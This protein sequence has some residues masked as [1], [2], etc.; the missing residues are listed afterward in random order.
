MRTYRGATVL[1]AR[2][3]ADPRRDQSVSVAPY[4]AHRTL[5]HPSANENSGP[6]AD[7]DPG[8]H[9]ALGR[10]AQLYWRRTRRKVASAAT[11]T[12]GSERIPGS[13]WHVGGARMRA[14]PREVWAGASGWARGAPIAYLSYTSVLSREASIRRGPVPVTVPVT[15]TLCPGERLP[16][17]RLVTAGAAT[18]WATRAETAR[19]TR[20]HSVSF[21]RTPIRRPPR[22]PHLPRPACSQLYGSMSGSLRRPA[23]QAR[24]TAGPWA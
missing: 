11:I 9:T 12:H 2:A 7:A 24:A 8:A 15:A 3:R 17:A 19:A 4:P 22:P 16:L 5:R 23:W 18:P 13:S 6:D 21:P 14:G 10:G 20:A 1:H